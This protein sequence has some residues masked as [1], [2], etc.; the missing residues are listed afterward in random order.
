MSLEAQLTELNTNVVKLISALEGFNPSVSSPLTED[1][2]TSS[3]Q[4]TS[5]ASSSETGISVSIDQLIELA[6]PFADANGQDK[7]LE[8]LHKYNPDAG[9][10]SEIPEDKRADLYQELKAA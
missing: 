8:L 4:T 6:I 1:S 3:E 2:A 9:K 5:A 7:L 10:L